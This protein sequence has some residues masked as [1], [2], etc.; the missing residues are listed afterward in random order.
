MTY[1]RAENTDHAKRLISEHPHALLMCGSTDVAVMLKKNKEVK[2]IIDLSALDALKHIEVT[3]T[4]VHIG[5]LATVTDILENETLS[6][7]LPLLTAAAAQFASR[8]VRNL[9]TLGGNIANASPAADLVTVLLVLRARVTLGSY[10]RE[11]TVAIDELFCGYKCTKLAHEI[12]LGIDIPLEAHQ[13]Y[14]R[15][16]GVRQ[17]LNIAK[18]S[19]AVAKYADGYAVSGASLNPYVIRFVHVE[20]LLNNGKDVSDDA[21]KK[22]LAQDI[23]PSG[24]FRSTKTY[25]MHVA[26][27]M[28]KE[29]LLKL[30]A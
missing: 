9:A 20:R 18:V 16:T 26:F 2:S 30:E 8:Q 28:V 5:A 22:A 6:R 4:H 13:W 21:I 1:Y 14:Y 27:N 12:I 24:S 7:T 3:Q 25:R 19:L 23:S 17:R 29:A 11:R 10:E 15:K